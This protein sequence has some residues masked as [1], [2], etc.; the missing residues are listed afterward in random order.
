M[1]S[2]GQDGQGRLDGARG[3]ARYLVIVAREEALLCEHLKQ[4]FV[5]DPEV[6]VFTDRRRPERPRWFGRE[7]PEGEADRWERRARAPADEP[8]V[9]WVVV[10]RT[11]EAVRGWTRSHD[12]RTPQRGRRAG[13]MEGL[14]DRQRVD[15]WIEE[16]QYLIG[17][18]IPGLLDDRDRL[19][20]KLDAAE[21]DA[22]KLRQEIGELRKEVNDLQS[23]TQYFRN[24]HAI[25]SE[26]LSQILEHV[27]QIQKPLNDVYRRLQVT[28]PSS[29][30][31]SGS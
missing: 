10:S 21:Q 2:P 30:P 26:A 13:V 3:T 23:E 8:A 17:R 25:M 9:R 24:E 11:H 14:E 5:G 16:S 19:K 12:T 6:R 29:V 31:T 7:A 28:Q 27:G 4:Q 18:L 22:A 20:G 1:P 15:R